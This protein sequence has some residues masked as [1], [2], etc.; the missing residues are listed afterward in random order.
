ME[1]VYNQTKLDLYEKRAKLGTKLARCAEKADDEKRREGKTLNVVRF[2]QGDGEY[3]PSIRV[4]GKWLRRYGFE[5]GDE[6][7]LMAGRG[8]VVITKRKQ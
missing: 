4:A 3:V 8:W 2:P 1:V 7:V 5:L 6:V